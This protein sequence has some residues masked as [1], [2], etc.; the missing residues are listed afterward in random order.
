MTSAHKDRTYSTHSS[1]CKGLQDAPP[2]DVGRRLEPRY[3]WI[4]N[5]EYSTGLISIFVISYGGR[6]NVRNKIPL[7]G[8]NGG[9]D[10]TVGA[11]N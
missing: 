6:Y 9:S 4:A 7:E 10:T 1:I 5:L 8:C 3:S 11:F 2:K